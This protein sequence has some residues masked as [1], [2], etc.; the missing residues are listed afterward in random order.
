MA[1]TSVPFD[2][3]QFSFQIYNAARQL[4][5]IEAAPFDQD[6]WY[7]YV[8][9]GYIGR[10]KWKKAFKRVQNAQFQI[11]LYMGRMIWNWGDNLH[12]VSDPIF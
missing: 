3:V 7:M 5:H 4:S 12:E 1:C 6:L 11:I 10:I 9:K 2:Q 8:Y